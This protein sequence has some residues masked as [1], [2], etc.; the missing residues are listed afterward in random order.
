MIY[1]I[2]LGSNCSVCYHLQQNNLKLKSFPFDWTKLSIT[3]LLTVLENNF[4][5]YVESLDIN[6][7][8]YNHPSSNTNYS[9]ILKNIYGITFAHEITDEN[10]LSIFK[11]KLI[12]RVNNFKDLDDLVIFIRI[13]LKPIKESYKNDII[14]LIK[15]LNNYSTNFILKLIL[16]TNIE[17]NDF[18]SN[19]QI[20]KFNDFDPDWHMNNIDWTN[21]FTN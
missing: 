11:D 4:S 20:Y 18:L 3:Q 21:I 8:S 14:K 1:Y 19:I 10:Q 5:N 15:L 13:E 17:F 6:K 2:S 9:I 7:I 12:Y 16:N